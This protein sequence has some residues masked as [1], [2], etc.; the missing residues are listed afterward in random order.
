MQ[1]Q[2]SAHNESA[3]DHHCSSLKW[4]HN[5]SLHYFLMS[6]LGE[7]YL[8]SRTTGASRVAWWPNTYAAYIAALPK[9]HW[10]LWG[11]EEEQQR[12][13]GAFLIYKKKQNL[14]SHDVGSGLI[15]LPNQTRTF[16][17]CS[18]HT[19]HSTTVSK[20]SLSSHLFRSGLSHLCLKKLWTSQWKNYYIS[21]IINI[22]FWSRSSWALNYTWCM[23]NI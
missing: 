4:V 14:I 2:D 15:D 12:F 22:T 16:Q 7:S 11:W 10:N 8:W 17:K 1:L 19:I 6:C 18:K 20:E 5:P 23:W 3:V 9:S 13:K 21:N